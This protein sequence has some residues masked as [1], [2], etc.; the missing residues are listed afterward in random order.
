M[1][2]AKASDRVRVAA[3]EALCCVLKS[4]KDSGSSVCPTLADRVLSAVVPLVVTA[5]TKVAA[6]YR[7]SVLQV[8]F[9]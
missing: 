8:L 3:L 6:R 5:A 1:K 7:L 4:L 2:D 9:C